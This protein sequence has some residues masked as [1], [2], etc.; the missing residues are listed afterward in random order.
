MLGDQEQRLYRR[1]PCRRVVLV[2]RQLGHEVSGIAQD[3]QLTAAGQGMGSSKVA[4]PVF[5]GH[6]AVRPLHTG[7]CMDCSV[8]FPE[9]D[10][11]NGDHACCAGRGIG[12][13]RQGPPDN[14]MRSGGP[15][16][17]NI[18]SPVSRKHHRARL[19]ELH[20]GA[21]LVQGEPAVGNRKIK[22]LYPAGMRLSL[23]RALSPSTGMSMAQNWISSSCLREC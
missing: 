3:A 10:A 7:G 13:G 17:F 11:L 19:S 1:T 12:S 8:I 21:A 23:R 5:V 4:V 20:E 16:G 18:S 22:A 2:P 14:C 15:F 9:Y 6:R